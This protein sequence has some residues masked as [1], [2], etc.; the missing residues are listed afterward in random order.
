MDSAVKNCNEKEIEL[1]QIYQGLRK[2]KITN[3]L[4][5][6]AVAGRIASMNKK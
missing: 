4:I 2:T 3:E 1:E 6:L 5:I